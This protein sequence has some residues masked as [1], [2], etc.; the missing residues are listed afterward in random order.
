MGVPGNTDRVCSLLR[1][2]TEELETK[3][4]EMLALFEMSLVSEAEP[5]VW[6]AT[7][8]KAEVPSALAGPNIQKP[9]TH[10]P[11]TNSRDPASAQSTL[12]SGQLN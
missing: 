1:R 3:S 8:E 2:G 7:L 10:L 4:F 12:L 5:L 11:K 9:R 6:E